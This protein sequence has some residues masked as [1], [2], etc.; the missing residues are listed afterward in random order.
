[1]LLPGG[2]IGLAGELAA[3]L[4]WVGLLLATR[5]VP[6]AEL[7]AFAGY[8]RDARRNDSKRRLRE[9]L[10]ALDGVDAELVDRL[11]RRREKPDAVA[12]QIGLSEEEAMARAVHALRRCGNGDGGEP[13]E[14]DAEL[15][16]LILVRR[17]HA[18]RQHGL[19]ALVLAGADPLDADLI[20][21]AAGAAGSRGVARRGGGN[22]AA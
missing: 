4:A 22:S 11:V 8:A 7:R 17:P 3:L 18:E 1:M 14:S 9:R 6:F 15:G 21:R 5:V 13:S 12:E 2:A 20:V 16:R 19:Q 10:A